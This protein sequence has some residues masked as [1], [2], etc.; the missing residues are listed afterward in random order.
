MCFRERNNEWKKCIFNKSKVVQRCLYSYRQRN[1]SSQWSK[2]VVD[3]LGFASWVHNILTTAMTIIVVDKSTDNAEPL[4]IC[5]L[6]QYSTAKKVFSSERDQNHD[7]KKEQALSITFLQ[8]DWFISQNGRSWLAITL[9]DKLTRARRRVQRC[10]DTYRQ[11]Q[12]SQSDCWITSN[13]GKNL[14]CGL[15][16][17][18]RSNPCTYVEN[19]SSFLV[20]TSKLNKAVS[21]GF[22]PMTFARAPKPTCKTNPLALF[23]ILRI[24]SLLLLTWANWNKRKCCLTCPKCKSHPVKQGSQDN[25]KM[26]RV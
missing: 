19:L 21:T 14:K 25:L 5:L 2:F 9:G 15:Q 6:P 23:C 22:E 20:N 12:I 4:S 26:T 3:S 24:G 10:Q 18:W 17:K 8:Y 1:S 16:T 11:R 7:T 13:C